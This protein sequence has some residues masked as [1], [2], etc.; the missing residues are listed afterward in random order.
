MPIRLASKRSNPFWT[1]GKPPV[2]TW[3]SG[4]ACSFPFASA[5]GTNFF[6]T[7]SPISL[8]WSTTVKAKTRY[9]CQPHCTCHAYEK[10]FGNRRLTS[11][12][13]HIL[14]NTFGLWQGRCI[15]ATTAQLLKDL[16]PYLA[17]L[18]RT[19]SVKHTGKAGALYCRYD[20][21]DDTGRFLVERVF[22]P[23]RFHVLQI[24]AGGHRHN[25]DPCCCC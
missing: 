6:Q 2:I 16:G 22:S 3:G 15:F 1:L 20:I 17:G 24:V 4:L 21:V 9:C 14:G 10:L 8:S 12:T 5:S 25:C 23:E 11:S 13:C 18:T 7:A 19:K